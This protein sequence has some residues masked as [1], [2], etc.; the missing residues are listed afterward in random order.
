MSEILDPFKT[1][2]SLSYFSKQAVMGKELP[3]EA[4]V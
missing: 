2:L 1:A 3:L 4:H